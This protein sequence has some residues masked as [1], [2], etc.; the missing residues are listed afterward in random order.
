MRLGVES[1]RLVGA[2]QNLP[3]PMDIQDHE[4]V[5]NAFHT[6]FYQGEDQAKAAIKGGHTTSEAIP[7]LL[8]GE[9]HH[10][11][12]HVRVHLYF[13]HLLYIYLIFCCRVGPLSSPPLTLHAFET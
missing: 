1:K 9:G 3:E 2:M 12:W 6:L 5:L 4:D 13:I 10:A 8:V 11:A 7:Y